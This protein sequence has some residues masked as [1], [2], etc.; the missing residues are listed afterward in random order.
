MPSGTLSSG[1]TSEPTSALSAQQRLKGRSAVLL[2]QSG[3]DLR[4]VE[5]RLMQRMRLA[6]RWLVQHQPRWP[7]W[8]RRLGSRTCSLLGIGAP[9]GRNIDLGSRAICRSAAKT[10]HLMRS[11][12]LR[13][14]STTSTS[15]LHFIQVQLQLW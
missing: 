12:N 3:V 8:A 9:D 6:S 4:S 5:Q 10:L 1:L 11:C 15:D 2:I 7:R 13:G 14:S